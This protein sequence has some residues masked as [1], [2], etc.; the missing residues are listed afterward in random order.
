MCGRNLA[1]HVQASVLGGEKENQ[2]ILGASFTLRVRG[3][4]SDGEGS[5]VDG[6]CDAC[7]WGSSTHRRWEG[8]SADFLR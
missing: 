1:G 3:L 4:G 8:H 6:G 7:T 2:M 5:S